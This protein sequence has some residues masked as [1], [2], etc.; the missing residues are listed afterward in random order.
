[1]P[2]RDPV[3]SGLQPR[4]YVGDPVQ[5]NCTSAPSKP[6]AAL[7]WYIQEQQ[8][9]SNYLI[10]FAPVST[11]DGLETSILGLHFRAQ[12]EHL[13]NGHLKLRCTATIAAVYFRE[14]TVFARAKLTERADPPKSHSMFA[15]INLSSFPSSTSSTSSSTTNTDQHYLHLS[16]HFQAASLHPSFNPTIISLP[17]PPNPP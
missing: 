8:A 7:T 2:E 11:S 13:K 17:P 15:A 1:T 4:Y 9:E 3:I 16:L 12:L 5:V 14:N 6:A 10:D